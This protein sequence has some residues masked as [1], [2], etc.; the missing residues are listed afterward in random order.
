MYNTH[1]NNNSKNSIEILGD[2]LYYGLDWLYTAIETT[3]MFDYNII[4]FWLLQDPSSESLNFFFTAS[5]YN[6]LGISSNQLLVAIILDLCSVNE[7]NRF[8]FLDEWSRSFLSSKDATIFLI[9]HPEAIFFLTQIKKVFLVEFLT[10][11]HP[12]VLQ[13]TDHQTLLSPITL[14]LQLLVVVTTSVVFVAFYFSF[15]TTSSKEEMVI[16]ADYLSSSHIV[17]SEKEIGSIDDVLMQIIL[18]GFVLL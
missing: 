13:Q 18:L 1:L 11:T 5:W 4:V 6:T 15:Y 9:S 16:D 12:A 8:I 10:E 14:L 7:L 17:A 2:F 3:Y